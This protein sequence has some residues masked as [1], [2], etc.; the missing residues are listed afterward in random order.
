MKTEGKEETKEGGSNVET[1]CSIRH[2]DN[3]IEWY[4]L[5]EKTTTTTTKQ[6]QQQ[7]QN[8]NKQT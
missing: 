1:C 2:V 8:N 6:Q 4:R 5:N 7:Q 3:G